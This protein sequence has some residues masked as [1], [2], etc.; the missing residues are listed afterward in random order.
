[1]LLTVAAMKPS[2]DGTSS[3]HVLS[4]DG[5]EDVKIELHMPVES[6]VGSVE[7]RSTEEGGNEVQEPQHTGFI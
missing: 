2:G 7:F 4:E 5:K 6:I 3:E 1:M